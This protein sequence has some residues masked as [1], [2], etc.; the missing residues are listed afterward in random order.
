MSDTNPFDILESLT[1]ENTV[2]VYRKVTKR[3][4]D[5]GSGRGK[6]GFGGKQE[7]ISSRSSSHPAV[8]VRYR[9]RVL[10]F[11]GMSIPPSIRPTSARLVRLL[12]GNAEFFIIGYDKGYDEM[13]F[14]P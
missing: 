5:V 11:L 9:R 6:A 14:H 4:R 1:V 10:R 2:A 12:K 3:R 8:T 7:V 13:F